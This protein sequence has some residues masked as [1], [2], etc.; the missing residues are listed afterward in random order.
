MSEFDKFVVSM[1]GNDEE[2]AEIYFMVFGHSET[3][4]ITFVLRQALIKT[5]IEITHEGSQDYNLFCAYTVL[6]FLK[7]N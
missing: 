7:D 6:K 5:V 1:F 4:P 3:D 2:D